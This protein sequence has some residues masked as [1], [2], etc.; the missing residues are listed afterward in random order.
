MGRATED[1]GI[2]DEVGVVLSWI[3][4]FPRRRKGEDGG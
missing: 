4:G 1:T 3:S 2:T